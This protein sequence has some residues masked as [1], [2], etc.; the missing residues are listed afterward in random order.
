MATSVGEMD[1]S[2]SKA[3]ARKVEEEGTASRS[4]H[5]QQLLLV[6]LVSIMRKVSKEKNLNGF[7]FLYI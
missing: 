2:T 5:T 7:F 6:L 3:R 1:F 4:I